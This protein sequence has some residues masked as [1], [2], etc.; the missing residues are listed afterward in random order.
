M[1][2]TKLYVSIFKRTKLY[3]QLK[4]NRLQACL[5]LRWLP[6][7]GN[8]LARKL[9]TH[10]KTPEAIFESD[11]QDFLAIDRIGTFHLQHFKKWSSL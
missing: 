6:S 3:Y 10:C 4:I 11:P 2:T 9:L 8:I 7:F 5:Y 1:I